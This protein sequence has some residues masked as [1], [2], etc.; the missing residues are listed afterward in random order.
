MPSARY[1]T[2]W[3]C[4]RSEDARVE[5]IHDQIRYAARATCL[6]A[7]TFATVTRGPAGSSRSRE[8]GRAK[9]EHPSRPAAEGFPRRGRAARTSRDLSIEGRGGGQTEVR[10]DVGI[11]GAPPSS[12]GEFFKRRGEGADSRRSVSCVHSPRGRSAATFA[13]LLAVVTR[14]ADSES[15]R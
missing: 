2:W 3:M 15:H 10:E 8:R 12:A 6:L 5:S 4:G 13:L 1:P 14:A 11:F 9:G 7:A